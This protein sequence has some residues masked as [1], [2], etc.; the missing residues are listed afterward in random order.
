M[1]AVESLSILALD[2]FTELEPFLV[3][4]NPQASLL[5]SGDGC[6][7]E[8]IQAELFEVSEIELP[9]KEGVD[10]VQNNSIVVKEAGVIWRD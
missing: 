5:L 9:S 1:L 2:I 4:Q 10:V 7:L 8:G 6:E 3:E